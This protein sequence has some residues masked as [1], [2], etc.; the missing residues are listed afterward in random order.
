MGVSVLGSTSID[1]A[2]L[3][4]LERMLLAALAVDPGR[5][6]STDALAEACWGEELPRTWNKQLQALV[7]RIRKL[8]GEHLIVTDDGAYRLSPTA[9]LD[10]RE[11]LETLAI[12]RSRAGSG[13]PDRAIDLF[14][15][16]LDLWRGSAYADLPDWEPARNAASRLEEERQSAEE[17][18][19]RA[20]LDCGEHHSAIA[21]AERLVGEQPL[22]EAR[23]QLLALANYR[24]G[25]QAEA[26]ATLRAVRQ[27]LADEL[28][29]EPSP[30]LVRLE[31]AILRQEPDLEPP[32]LA[33][34]A[35]ATCPYRGLSAFSVHDAESFYGRA[36]AVR[37][38]VNR[39]EHSGFLAL[40]GVS[41]SGKSSLALAGVAARYSA[42]GSRVTILRPSVGWEDPLIALAAQGHRGELVVIDQFEEIFQLGR[43][44][45][46]DAC[47]LL[48]TIARGA[49]SVLLTVRS[50]FLD[51]AAA[52]PAMGAL[53]AGQV[54][55]VAAMTRD[56]LRIAIEAPARDAGL[57]LEAGLAELILR[58]AS[59][60]A[61]ALPLMSHALVETWMLREGAV[62]TVTGYEAA[63]GIAGAIARSADALLDELDAAGRRLCR[64]TMLRLV[65]RG[66]EGQPVRRRLAS[67]SVAD[68]S[69]RGELVYRLT[70]A[71]LVSVESDSIV[72]A[73]ESIATAWP[74]LVAW[75]DE[76]AGDSET[77]T[78]LAA[79]A[80]A[81]S[82]AGQTEDDLYRGARLRAVREFIGR[83]DPALTT[84]E[85]DFVAASVI[86][87][88]AESTAAADRAQRDQVQNR[89][90]RVALASVSALVVVALVTAGA[91]VVQGAA[92]RQSAVE[93]EESAANARVEALLGQCLR[94]AF[95]AATHLGAHR[96]RAVPSRPR[97]SPLARRAHDRP[98]RCRRARLDEL[99]RLD[100]DRGRGDTGR[101]VSGH[102]PRRR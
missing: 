18:L 100:R 41:G 77:M 74:A 21:A 68:D 90:L 85:A 98:H 54:Q 82:R 92:A 2:H 53:I 96:R 95:V 32:H 13:E 19:W 97:G 40:T 99:P 64:D 73:H 49:A 59:G 44:S 42:N 83:A 61:A 48:A 3:R 56:D 52:L 75:L 71:R 67:E 34:H 89:R 50:D 8:G 24:S 16:A 11:F 57:R 31:S 87:D 36:D 28:G 76:E 66:P 12:A 27:K 1:G 70:R 60:S 45:I 10:A 46:D 94:S 102:R 81:W 7:G 80:Q 101:I 39:L 6:V 84:T 72:I 47:R 63:G 33:R 25:R 69:A 55:V 58:D 26:L 79:G 5:T 29:L 14:E 20:H 35:S 17:E 38:A 43:D 65:T 91:A 23:W 86:R 15:R 30:G 62:L 4:R 22:R 88:L 37:M 9:Q 93:A 51:R 78:Q